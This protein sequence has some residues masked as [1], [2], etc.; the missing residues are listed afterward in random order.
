MEEKESERIDEP[1]SMKGE[2]YL[3]LDENTLKDINKG[4]IEIVID[5][6]GKTIWV[7][8]DDGCELRVSNIQNLKLED[9]RPKEIEKFGCECIKCGFK[10]YNMTKEW[11]KC[12]KC[13]CTVSSKIP[14]KHNKKKG[15]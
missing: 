11:N 4:N 1:I 7:N 13:G 5:L 8:S 2:M 6:H 10:G 14:N 15:N 9:N 3:E 12:P